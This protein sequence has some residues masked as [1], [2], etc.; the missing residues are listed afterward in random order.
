MLFLAGYLCVLLCGSTFSFHAS[1]ASLIIY[2][3]IYVWLCILRTVMQYIQTYLSIYKIPTCAML[4]MH[5]IIGS[6]TTVSVGVCLYQKENVALQKMYAEKFVTQTWTPLKILNVGVHV[7]GTK[8]KVTS[9]KA[10]ILVRILFQ[11]LVI[12]CGNNRVWYS[13]WHFSVAS[14]HFFSFFIYIA[15]IFS[16]CELC[17]FKLYLSL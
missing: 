4:D 8:Y 13:I 15:G 3:Y 1:V 10:H 17:T 7:W 11:S 2:I 9:D 14:R 6:L 12:T 16:Y 5:R